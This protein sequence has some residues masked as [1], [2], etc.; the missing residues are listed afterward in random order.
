[1]RLREA[2]VVAS[3]LALAAA[4]CSRLSFVKPTAK[5]GSLDRTAQVVEVHETREGAQ[6]SSVRNRLA[7]AQ[8]HLARGDLDAAERDTRQALKLK[9]DSADGYTLLAAIAEGRG[10]VA[11][12]GAHYRRAAELAP[13]QGGAL[14]NYGTWLCGAG[15]AAES[16]S[17]F[18]RALAD[19]A[20]PTPASALA[21][22]GACADRAGQAGRA[23]R[24]LR[25]AISLDPENPL[26]LGA[27]AQVE[28]RA[29]RYLAARA[30]S[31][32]RLAAAPADARALQLASQIEQKLGD[33][34]AADHY[35]R[36]LR[37][38]FPGAVPG[39]AG[40]N[41]QR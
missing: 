23:E 11:E 32:R 41:T 17:W 27:L 13:T 28:F 21:N 10:Q 2:I 31:Q 38:E 5:R 36:R 14:N 40:E 7:L 3:L 6:R 34:A 9:A 26:A 15:R 29:G 12:A 22:A 24:D 1:M 4:G 35:G 18:E 39:N 20:Y 25:A 37:E 30:F 19:P 33:M 8:G 16:L